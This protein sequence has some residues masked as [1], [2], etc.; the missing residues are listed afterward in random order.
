MIKHTIEDKTE[1]DVY[2]VIYPISLKEY[3]RVN[4]LLD[5]EN[6]EDWDDAKREK[7]GI[8][9]D[10]TEYVLGIRFDDGAMLDWKLCYGQHNCYDDVLFQY[11]NGNWTDLDCTYEL[12]NIKIDAGSKIYIVELDK[13]NE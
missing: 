1:P 11:P 9:P 3:Q 7:L 12:D 10:S 13:Q 5:I 4:T 8:K 6:Y 2:K